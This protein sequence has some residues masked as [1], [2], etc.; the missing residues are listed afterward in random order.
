MLLPLLRSM[1]ARAQ[2]QAAPKRLLI[3]HHALGSPLDRWRPAATATTQTFTLPANSAPFAPLQSNMVLIDGLNLVT[4]T[5]GPDT[6]GNRGGQNTPEGGMVALMTGVPTLGNIGQQDHCAGGPSIDQLLLDRSPF[7][8]G[9]ASPSQT[10]FGSLQLAADIRSARDEV[11]PRVMSYRAPIANADPSLARQPLYPETQPLNAFQ[12][13]FGSGTSSATGTAT[14][15]ARELSVLDFMRSD[16]KRLRTLAPSSEKPRMDAHADAI[17]Q[18]ELSIRQGMSGRT[19]ICTPPAAPPTFPM[20]ASQSTYGSFYHT[21]QL[22]GADEYD[23]A[24][25]SNHPHQVIGQ[26]HLALIQ[27]AFV[28]DLTRVATFSWSSA[29]SLVVFPTSFGGA[30]L[31]QYSPAVSHFVPLHQSSADVTAWWTAIDLFYAQQSALAIQNL[32]AAPDVDGNSLLDNTVVVYVT[33]QTRAWDS[34]Q[35]SV[36]LAVFGGRNTGVRGGTFL[37]ITG[38]A[39]ASADGPTGNRPFNDFWLALAGAFGVDLKALGASTQYTG[40]VSGVFG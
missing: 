25:P 28:C 7:L 17:Q 14:R 18:L 5:T 21:S 12:S 9:A 11:A 16:L 29:T 31:S 27:A 19:P 39:L 36:P 10:P 40:P 6:S 26:T 3:L 15:L 22:T 24:D 20:S 4:A 13:L 8:G 34:M 32:A 30:T 2:G 38:G 33:E 37:K 1:E 23:P 35:R